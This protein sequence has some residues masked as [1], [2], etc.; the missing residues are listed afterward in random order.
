M[1]VFLRGC[2]E[3]RASGSSSEPAEAL[4]CDDVKAPL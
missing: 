4:R 1:D 2:E 3:R